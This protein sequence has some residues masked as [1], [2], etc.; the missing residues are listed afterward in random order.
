MALLPS[1]RTYRR[2]RSPGML[3]ARNGNPLVDSLPQKSGPPR[4]LDLGAT[5]CTP[6]ARPRV[7]PTRSGN[8]LSVTRLTLTRIAMLPSSLQYPRRRLSRFVTLTSLTTLL[9]PTTPTRR[10]P[11]VQTLV[12]AGS[13][14]AVMVLR[15]VHHQ[16]THRPLDRRLHARIQRISLGLQLSKLEKHSSTRAMDT[17]AVSLTAPVP[18]RRS[19]SHG[20]RLHFHWQKPFLHR[21][22]VPLDL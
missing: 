22:R 9:V 1:V 11:L 17:N 8:L 13:T 7:R 12:I 20:G 4:A 2:R 6:F 3:S 10:Q 19:T 18:R 14:V 16:C 15:R 5:T 21:V